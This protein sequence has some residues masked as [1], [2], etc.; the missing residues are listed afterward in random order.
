M[1]VD[2]TQ[3]SYPDPASSRAATSQYDQYSSSY[4]STESYSKATTQTTQVHLI[5]IMIEICLFCGLMYLVKC[6]EFVRNFFVF[7]FS[8]TVAT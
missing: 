5:V 4:Y 6:S 8:V 2:L 1:E 3:S 7:Q